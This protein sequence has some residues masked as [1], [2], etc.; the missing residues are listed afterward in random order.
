MAPRATFSV[1]HNLHELPAAFQDM[2]KHSRDRVVRMGIND[3]LRRNEN[4]VVDRIQERGQWSDPGHVKKRVSSIL[5]GTKL[6]GKIRA[7]QNHYSLATR[8]SG[9][10]DGHAGGKFRSAKPWGQTRNYKGFLVRGKYNDALLPAVRTGRGRNAFKVIYGASVAR[11][12][13]REM[14][15]QNGHLKTTLQRQIEANMVKHVG[16]EQ[17]RIK[18]LHGL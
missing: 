6:V 13:E 2:S 16:L 3:T 7:E 5:A 18:S 10:S 11:E 12:L 9:V 17:Q 4:K 14:E 1:S 15:E 8:F